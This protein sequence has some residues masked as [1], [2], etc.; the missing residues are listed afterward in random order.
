MKKTFDRLIDGD[1]EDVGVNLKNMVNSISV[2]RRTMGEAEK[3]ITESTLNF[4]SE[5]GFTPRDR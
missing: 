4:S 2:L 1:G 5:A 3:W